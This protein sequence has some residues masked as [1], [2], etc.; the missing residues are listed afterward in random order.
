MTRGGIHLNDDVLLIKHN[1]LPWYNELEDILDIDDP[2]F[3]T[4]LRERILTFGKYSL[5]S[6]THKEAQLE[7][8]HTL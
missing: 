1:L 7:K 8:K 6:I 3:P 5:L 4:P 2:K